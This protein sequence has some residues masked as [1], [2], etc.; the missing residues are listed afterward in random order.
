MFE[1]AAKQSTLPYETFTDYIFAS[2]LGSIG[3]GNFLCDQTE[4]S[5][6]AQVFTVSKQRLFL[7]CVSGNVDIDRTNVNYG[8]NKQSPDLLTSSCREVDEV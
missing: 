5:S 7:E 4:T 8:L 2:T 1:I 3:Y 6:S